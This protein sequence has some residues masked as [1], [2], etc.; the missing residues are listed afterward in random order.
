M[1]TVAVLMSTYNGE[2]YLKEQLDS[3]FGQRGVRVR[4]F[5]R[6]DGST[7]ATIPIL[8]DYEKRYPVE[9]LRDGENIGPGASFLRLLY[10]SAD[11]PGI[12]YVAFADQDDVWLEDK[13]ICAVRAIRSTQYIGP[14]LYSS[15]QSLFENG[16]NVGLRYTT[17]QSIE[18]IPHLTRN[19]IAGCTFV[20]N[21]ELSQLIA[22]AESQSH[23]DAQLIRFRLHD[24]WIM[25]VAICCGHVLYDEDSHML[26]RIHSDNVVGVKGVSCRQKFR[27][28]K[29][30]VTRNDNANLRSLTAQ[31]LLKL[32]PEMGEES[33]TI[34]EL[35]ATY[36]RSIATRIRLMSDRRVRQGC[37]EN[38]VVFSAKVLLGLV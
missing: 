8:I 27:R 6:D 5:A 23:P 10:A 18:L 35:Y 25:L 20:W 17:P 1:P 22:G 24:A 37:G 33:K 30:L 34:L 3:I 38:P 14:I 7:D 32:Y 13:L 12:D 16:Q 11:E 29:G 31:E 21:K 36:K 19:T 4:L 15:N 28:L 9:L 2:R 26:Y